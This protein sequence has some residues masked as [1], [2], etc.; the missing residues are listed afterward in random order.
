MDIWDEY[1]HLWKTQSAFFSWIRGGVRRSLWNRSPI[2]LEF[3]KNNRRKINNPN[4]R[5]KVAQVWGGDCALCN[6][7]FILKD[8]EVDHKTGNHS[9]TKIEDIQKFIE[10]IVLVTE[11]D[12][13]MV[14]KP[15][16]KA[17]SM[18]DK[19]GISIEDALISRKV[20]AIM[21]DKLDKQFLI[22]RGVVPDSTAAKRKL[23]IIDEL[24]RRP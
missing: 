17:K 19:Q 20:I 13:Q 1:P 24:K 2:K 5:G 4:P 6:N 3:I 7:T 11:S 18:A 22:D 14:C 21:K 10:G 12:L 16:H 8:L 9:L 23:Q 15:C